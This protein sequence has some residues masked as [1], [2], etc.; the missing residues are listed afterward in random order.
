MKYRHIYIL[1]TVFAIIILGGLFFLFYQ[2]TSVPSISLSQELKGKTVAVYIEDTL[3]KTTAPITD[4]T[5]VLDLL[6][7]LQKEH[8]F[9][10]ET[11]SYKDLGKIVVT[12]GHHTNGD[13]GEVWHYYVNGELPI[14]SPDA[15]FLNSGDQLEWRFAQPSI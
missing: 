12:I 9:L 3:T 15:Y 2:E 11:E 4:S 13:R 6:I 1:T 8:Q 5:S 14:V 7:A 10:F